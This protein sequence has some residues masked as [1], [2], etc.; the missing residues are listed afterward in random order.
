MLTQLEQLE[1]I[2]NDDFQLLEDVGPEAFTTSHLLE[3][4]EQAVEQL[5]DFHRRKKI[6]LMIGAVATGWVIALVAAW[7]YQNMW[8]ALVAGV[9][10]L[11]SSIAFFAGL[12][13]LSKKKDGRAALEHSLL[14]IDNELYNR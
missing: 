5:M 2:A 1:Q 9:A 4:R 3:L 13:I 10:L 8:L 12:W 6:N 11:V 7:S 14:L